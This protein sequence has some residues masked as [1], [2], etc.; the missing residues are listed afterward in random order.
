MSTC[1]HDESG[2]PRLS[3]SPGGTPTAS[4]CIAGGGPPGRPLEGRARVNVFSLPAEGPAAGPAHAA[5]RQLQPAQPPTACQA[6]ATPRT[7]A[8]PSRG[9]W[10]L[11]TMGSGVL[12]PPRPLA[13]R[14]VLDY[15][16]QNPP[17]GGKPRRQ[18]QGANRCPAVGAGRRARM[19]HRGTAGG[20]GA[21]VILLYIYYTL[22]PL[23]LR[24]APPG[25]CWCSA[26]PLS[27]SGGVSAV[28]GLREGGG[29]VGVPSPQARWGR[30]RLGAAVGVVAPQEPARRRAEKIW[31]DR[32]R[33]SG[34]AVRGGGEGGVERGWEGTGKA[35]L[36]EGAWLWGACGLLRA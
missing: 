28:R 6:R 32:G 36:A 20:V 26:S 16:T 24:S 4:P 1:L 35:L 8:A 9:A 30:R 3:G 31:K 33:H 15:G 7:A 27:P 22:V 21:P 23:A 29:P 34:A 19:R 12:P 25:R 5:W 18:P 13:P 2:S 11:R 10:P 17:A 14:P